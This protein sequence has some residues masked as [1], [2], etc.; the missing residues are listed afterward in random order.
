MDLGIMLSKIIQTEKS[1]ILYDITY[2]ESKKYNNLV[3]IPKKGA[4]F[5]DGESTSG[6]QR[7][8]GRGSDYTRW[9]RGR[10]KLC[11]SRMCCA[12]RDYTHDSVVTVNGK[13]PLKIA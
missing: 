6:H 7:R 2:V 9:G 13:Q 1:Q 10:H 5:T 3:N 11:G 4:R 12:T 8:K